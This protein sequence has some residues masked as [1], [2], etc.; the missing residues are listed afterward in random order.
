MAYPR[1]AATYRFSEQ[2]HELLDVLVER[3]G[4][5]KTAMIE[6]LIRAESV[7]ASRTDASLSSILV[8]LPCDYGVKKIVKKK[9]GRKVRAVPKPAPDVPPPPPAKTAAAGLPR[10]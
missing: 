1:R 6:R 5:D 3:T 4:L 10:W 2:T 9:P 8:K 7:L